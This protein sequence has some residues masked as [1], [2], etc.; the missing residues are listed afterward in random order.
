MNSHVPEEFPRTPV[1]IIFEGPN[2]SGKTTLLDNYLSMWDDSD[3]RVKGVA[4]KTSREGLENLWKTLHGIRSAAR[5]R[6]EHDHPQFHTF[7]DR[8]EF[9]SDLVYRPIIEKQD[10]VDITKHSQLIIDTLN[11]LNAIFVYVTASPAVIQERYKELGEHYHA[12]GLDH[13]DAINKAYAREFDKLENVVPVIKVINDGKYDI[14]QQC[15]FIRGRIE[16][17]MIKKGL[18]FV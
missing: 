2:R 10:S 17:A 15:Y 12:G 11:E 13:I 16:N 8:L 1:T 9:P 7:L 18:K 4:S 6:G 14:G 3:L 5:V